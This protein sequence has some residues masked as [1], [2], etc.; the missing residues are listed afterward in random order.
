[1]L[2]GGKRRHADELL[3]EEATGRTERATLLGR[4]GFASPRLLLGSTL[5]RGAKA[6]D[7]LDACIACWTAEHVAAGSAIVTPSTSPIDSCGLRMELWR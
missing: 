2:R 4:L 5:S 3:E 1:V 6:D 7:L